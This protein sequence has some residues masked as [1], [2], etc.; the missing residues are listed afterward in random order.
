[1]HHDIE[2][3]KGNLLITGANGE[4][5]E[6][7]I[8]ELDYETGQVV[9]TLDLKTV[10]QR[11]RQAGYVALE[12]PDWF[13]HNTIT[14][15]ESDDTIIISGRHQST[16]AKISWPDGEIKWILAPHYGWLP[17]FE[18]YL[19]TPI[20]EGFEWSFQ[21]HAPEI[22]PD[23]DGNP[24][25]IDILLFDNGNQ[26]FAVDPE[27]Q[28]AITAGEISKPELYSRMVHYRI[29]ESDMTIQQIWQFGKEYGNT[30]YSSAHGDADLLPN[31]NRLGVFDV[32]PDPHNDTHNNGT[33]FEVTGDSGI[34]WSAQAVSS[35]SSGVHVEYKL[36]RK[37]IYHREANFLDIGG[38][39]INLIPQEILK[40]YGLIE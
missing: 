2:V 9:N 23:L 33:F 37:A 13:H 12:N 7:F 34:V 25:T 30:L 40:Y 32:E 31:G 24:E 14:W 5:K 36:E 16:V 28:R 6:D 21:Q 35:F 38:L 27:I 26:R 3:Y 20:G 1:V 10:L 19:L 15:D 22:L 17:M 4:T 29:N 8:Y 39:V 18:K 11:S